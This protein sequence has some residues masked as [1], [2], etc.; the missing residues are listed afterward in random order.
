MW[1]L[2]LTL[3][4]NKPKEHSTKVFELR[5]SSKNEVIKIQN[6]LIDLGKALNGQAIPESTVLGYNIELRMVSK[7]PKEGDVTVTLSYK[8]TSKEMVAVLEAGIAGAGIV[9]K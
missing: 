7:G 2:K 5:E 4:V 9:L 3:T 6:K 8:N 1:S